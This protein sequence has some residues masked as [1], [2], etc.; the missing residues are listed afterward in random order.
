MRVEMAH[1]RNQEEETV[2]H[3]PT[4][5]KEKKAITIFFSSFFFLITII[6]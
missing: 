6:F 3:F 1:P 4:K 5:E 2:T